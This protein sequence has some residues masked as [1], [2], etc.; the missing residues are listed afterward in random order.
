MALEMDRERLNVEMA[1]L[2]KALVAHLFILFKTSLHYGEGHTAVDQ[3][4]GKLL[5]VV[6]EITRRNEEA[7]LRLRGGHLYLGELRL[8]PDLANFEAPRF[9]MEEMRRHLLGRITFTPELTAGDLRSFAYTLREID[10]ASLSDQYTKVLKGMQHKKVET[11][12]V[13][14]LRDDVPPAP[15]GGIV[16][17]GALKAFPLYRKVLAAMDEVSAQVA[18]GQ[19]LRLKESKRLVQHMIDLLYSHEATLLGLSTMR[20]YDRSSQHHAANVCILSLVMGKR[21]GISKFQLCELGLAALFHDLGNADVPRGVMDKPGDLTLK[22]REIMENHTILG[23]KKM[24]KLKGL[25]ALTSR[26][27]TGIFEHH[28]HAD[29]SGYPRLPYRRLSLFGRIIGI[30]DSYDGLTSSR[31]T[32]RIAYPPHKALR[33]MLSQAGKAYDAALLKLFV[34][35]IG[36]HAVGSLL[37]L[38]TRELAVVVGSSDDPTQWA[39]PRVR[40]IADGEGR[41]IE[42]EVV[43]VGGYPDNSRTI[44]ATLDPYLFDLDVSRYFH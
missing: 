33:V 21:L 18:A 29:F 24:M 13:E 20:S 28:L 16:K 23:V 10:P 7:S 26:I 19:S 1:R 17:E 27:I 12:E 31:V 9:V 4:V 43:D 25:D 39:N 35:C 32:G 38:D 34:N 2:G 5:E 40:I 15:S 22:E 11:I 14:I 30:A 42:G 8:K 3:P 41:E 36:I 44:V 37:L 6:R